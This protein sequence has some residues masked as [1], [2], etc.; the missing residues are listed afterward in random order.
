MEYAQP[1]A[2]LLVAAVGAWIALQQMLIARTKLQHDLF[3]R[4]HAIF[5]AARMF[6]AMVGIKAGHIDLSDL[7]AFSA[8]TL[9][10]EF[11]LN[12]EIAEYLAQLSRRGAALAGISEETGHPV[13]GEVG[14]LS[15]AIA[16]K[17]AEIRWFNDQ[18]DVLKHK[19]APFLR[20][21]R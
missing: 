9:D 17:W 11:L 21:K 15:K 18:L 8:K 10:A 4:R 16:E 13:S 6:I 12:T 7:G 2:L 1:I 20:F 14:D 19:F 3:D 5:H